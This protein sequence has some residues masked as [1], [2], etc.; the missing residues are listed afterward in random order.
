[1][2]LPEIALRGEALLED[3][4]AARPQPGTGCFWW[5]GQLSFI[6]KLG[7]QILFLDPY[8][9]PNPDRRTPPLFAPEQVTLADWVICTHDHADHI[10]PVAVTGLAR[11][12]P[13]AR[14]AFPN[15]HRRRMLDL[16]VPEDRM[17]PMRPEETLEEAGMAITAVRAQ[18]EFFEEGP[19][20]FPYLGYVLRGAGVSVYDSGDTL[21]YEGLQTTLRRFGRLDLMLL[22]IN[23]R[24]AARYRRNC[25]GNMTY[26]EAVDLAG[27]LEPE[28]VVP[29]HWDMFEGNQED[30]GKFLDYLAVKWPARR[31]WVGRVG[32]RVT[33]H[34]GERL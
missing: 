17:R 2:T 14:F 19:D 25:I 28:L 23:G 22:P 8:L 11:S 30:P 34:A 9:D 5:L 4:A 27:E 3:I 32:E 13:Q 6:L 26:Q 21:V 18:H 1:M 33:F 31:A 29:A 16:G 12:S 10:D 20:G 15:P 7:D 24:D